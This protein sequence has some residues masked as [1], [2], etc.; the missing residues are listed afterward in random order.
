MGII[1]VLEDGKIDQSRFITSRF[2]TI[3][4]DTMQ[5]CML[6]SNQLTAAATINST[7]PIDFGCSVAAPG[8]GLG[9][10]QATSST[11]RGGGYNCGVKLLNSYQ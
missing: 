6:A 4:Y 7:A 11:P 9:N 3:Q 8:D 1:G 10:A 2:Q 5:Q